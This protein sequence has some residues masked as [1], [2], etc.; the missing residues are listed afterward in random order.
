MKNGGCEAESLIQDP[1]VE[2]GDKG[3]NEALKRSLHCFARVGEEAEEAELTPGDGC[4]C[5]R[6]S[7]N[8]SHTCSTSEQITKPFPVLKPSSTFGQYAL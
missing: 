3:S 2:G 6:L 5:T 1:N 7:H 4:L 8:A